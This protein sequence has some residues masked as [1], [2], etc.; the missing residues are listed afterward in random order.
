MLLPMLALP[1][2]TFHALQPHHLCLIVA[3]DGVW[4]ASGRAVIALLQLAGGSRVGG[5]DLTPQRCNPARMP[6]PAP[7]AR[8]RC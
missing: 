3:T 5:C 6:L 7:P 1:A 2:V 8:C 4:E